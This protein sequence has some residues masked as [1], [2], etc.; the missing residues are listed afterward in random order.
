MMTARRPARASAG[1]TG[2]KTVRTRRHREAL[3]CVIAMRTKFSALVAMKTPKTPKPRFSAAWSS[4]FSA[5][6]SRPPASGKQAKTARFWIIR[7]T[8]GRRRTASTVI[9]STAI[10]T[11]GA[12]PSSDIASTKEMNE[13]DRLSP[14]VWI[15]IASLTTERPMST[16]SRPTGCQSSAR[17]VHAAPASDVARRPACATT[18][19]LR[20]I[21]SA[22][23]REGGDP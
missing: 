17:E 8:G 13:P 18:R 22:Y 23:R 2:R 16:A 1:S 20:P 11:A 5:R 14:R 12:G 19:V 3:G 10:A 21:H 15:V 7:G 9:E 6:A 4:R